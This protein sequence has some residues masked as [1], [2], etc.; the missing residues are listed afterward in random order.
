MKAGTNRLGTMEMVNPELAC[1]PTSAVCLAALSLPRKAICQGFNFYCPIAF[2]VLARDKASDLLMSREI[3]GL[4][5][6]CASI[7]RR[8][9][10]SIPT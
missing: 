1:L 10:P 5:R 3:P 8:M 9:S 6:R 4:T 2:W 7:F